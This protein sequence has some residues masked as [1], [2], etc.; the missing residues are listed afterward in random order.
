MLAQ[1]A[2][3]PRH[4]FLQFID[5]SVMGSIFTQY[6]SPALVN[7]DSTPTFIAPLQRKDVDL[8]L[9]AARKLGVAMPV[10]AATREVLQTH[11]GLAAQ[12]P[13]PDAYLAKD[14][15]ALFETLADAERLG[16]LR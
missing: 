8:G 11:L 5:N 4:A 12:R 2:G 1:K 9:D 3:A 13:D 7:L 15:A 10:A 6:K 14:F 16:N